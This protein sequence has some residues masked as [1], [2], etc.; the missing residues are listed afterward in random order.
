M[1]KILRGETVPEDSKQVDRIR[2][3]LGMVFQQFNL[4][5]HMTVLENAIEAPI[6]VQR[7]AKDEVMDTARQVLDKV[8]LGDRFLDYPAHLSGDQQ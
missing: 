5:S 2:T 6:H 1:K 7:R 3:H 8:G 4:W